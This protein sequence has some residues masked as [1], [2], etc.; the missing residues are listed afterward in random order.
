MTEH[1]KNKTPPNNIG[2]MS[3]YYYIYITCRVRA[4]I[5]HYSAHFL[6]SLITYED[7]D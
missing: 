6:P 4:H 7:D 1:S 3:K 2:N 5:L